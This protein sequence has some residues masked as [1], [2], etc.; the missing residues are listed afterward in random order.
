M[1][2]K[3]ILGLLIIVTLISMVPLPSFAQVEAEIISPQNGATVQADFTTVEFYA[4][5]GTVVLIKLDGETVGKVVSEG[6]NE[7]KFDKNLEIGQHILTLCAYDSTDTVTAASVFTVEYQANETVVNVPFNGGDRGGVVIQSKSLIAGTDKN[8]ENVLIAPT[9]L[10][11]SNGEANGSIGYYINTPIEELSINSISGSYYY[12]SNNSWTMKKFTLQYD[13]LLM[14]PGSFE[15]ETRGPNGFGWP[16]AR[17]LFGF[18]GKITGTDYEYPVGEW[19]T[20]RHDIDLTVTP[21]THKTYINDELVISATDTNKFADITQIKFQYYVNHADTPQGFAIDNLLLTQDVHKNGFGEVTYEDADGNLIPAKNNVIE[22][23]TNKILLACD[24]RLTQ[25]DAAKAEVYADGERLAI[26]KAII[27]SDGNVSLTFSEHLP[28]KSDIKILLKDSGSNETLVKTLKTDTADF[29]I[30]NILF[31]CDSGELFE[32]AQ[33]ANTQNVQA[34]VTL[35]NITATD[36][37]GV[38]LLV[39]YEGNEVVRLSAKSVTIPAGTMTQSE[40][41]NFSDTEFS[42]KAEIECHF[43]DSYRTRKV[44]SKVYGVK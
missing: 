22:K 44:L 5:G 40:V 9:I 20:V 7:Y 4:S 11:G 8:G 18:D 15:I 1:I 41:V 23:E 24:M 37:S 3:K 14:K 26:E 30:G 42:D 27:D 28:D 35:K 33:L 39:A 31:W 29:G 19:M 43:I 6:L 10:E 34:A 17:N 16:G 32:S 21:P 2:V 25:A 36:K 38:L 12:L 13:L